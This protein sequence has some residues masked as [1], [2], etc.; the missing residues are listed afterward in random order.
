M[1]ALSGTDA[2]AVLSQPR[3]PFDPTTE[4]LYRDFCE[5]MVRLA[6]VRYPQL[7]TLERQLQQVII[8][9][10]LPLLGPGAGRPGGFRTSSAGIARMSQASSA[11][12]AS[13]G[14]VS[15]AAASAV[16]MYAPAV[17]AAVGASGADSEQLQNVDVVLYLQTQA[18]ALQQLYVAFV[19][20]GLDHS[21]AAQAGV[22]EQVAAA[23]ANQVPVRADT[24]LD[25]KAWWDTPVTV[26]QVL[27]VLQLTGVLQHWQLAADDVAALLLESLMSVADPEGPR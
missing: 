3:Y 15:Q 12:V 9:H 18:L 2:A 22:A 25:S 1:Q 24:T 11:T 7:T 8:Q 21:A 10:L 14:A 13:S 23:T 19:A 5:L 16:G 4:L 27:S 26:R 20:D 17:A 6:A